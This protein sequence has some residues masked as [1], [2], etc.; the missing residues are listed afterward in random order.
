MKLFLFLS[1]LLMV[2]YASSQSPAVIKNLV[3][4]GA[5]IRGI[6]YCGAISALEEKNL[7]NN[8]QRVGGT[9]A[10]AITALAISLGYNSDEIAGIISNTAFRKFNDGRFMFFGGINRMN[11]YYGWYKGQRLENWIASIIEKKTGNTDITFRQLKEN[12]F[13]DL[14]ITGTSLTRQ[15]A[16][17]FSYERYPD[18]K[19]KDAVRISV[20]IPLYFEAIFI[21]SAGETFNHPKNKS[22]LEVMADGGFIANFP[23]R[24]FDSTKYADNTLENTFQIN[25]ETLGFRIDTEAQITN[26]SSTRQLASMQIRS[27]KD[28]VAAFYNIIIEHLNRQT[29]TEDDWQR[30]ISISDGK[31]APRIR[32][33]SRQEVQILISNGRTA[34]S[35]YLE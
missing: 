16:V 22:D 24:L 17:V 9:S 8:I 23:I 10:G 30:T 29:L 11:R 6:A 20:S 2:T 13:K 35:S 26:D 1:N 32:K 4:E 31:I 12:G 28:Y 34:T 33:L 25:H 5:G 3:F 27:F 19:I 14:Y 21:N 18:M 15:Q 7:L